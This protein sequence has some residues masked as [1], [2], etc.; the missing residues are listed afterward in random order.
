MVLQSKKISSPS[1]QQTS[2]RPVNVPERWQVQWVQSRINKCNMAVEAVL[3]KIMNDYHKTA[4]LVVTKT[5][6]NLQAYWITFHMASQHSMKITTHCKSPWSPGDECQCQTHFTWRS[7]ELV[8]V[9]LY[10]ATDQEAS[11]DAD[12]R[13]KNYHWMTYC[14]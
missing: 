8:G 10:Q 5:N 13:L 1:I 4:E 7:R 9:L 3:T 2:S 12:Q 11:K 6:H 14:T